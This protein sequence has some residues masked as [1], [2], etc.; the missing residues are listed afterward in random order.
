[1]SN[2]LTCL[3]GCGL[4]TAR[5]EGRRV[6]YELAHPRLA[7]A[8]A[9]LAGLTL[10]VDDHEHAPVAD[11]HHHHPV[12]DLGGVRDRQRRVLWLVLAANAT[13]MVAEIAG[14][15]PFL[16]LALLSDAAHMASDVSGLGIAL[17]AQALLR[18][19]TPIA[20]PT[21]SSGPRCWA[22]RQRGSP[23]CHIGVDRVRGHPALR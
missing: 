16:L 11:E 14:V 17:V 2:H 18:R 13:F 4:V 3:R 15:S 8:L 5:L 1:M 21:A 23:R 7:H 19:P 9:D 12:A 10:P 22:H 6:R 20:T